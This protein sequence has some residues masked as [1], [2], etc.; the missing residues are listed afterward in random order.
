MQSIDQHVLISKPEKRSPPIRIDVCIIRAKYYYMLGFI[1][2]EEENLEKAFKYYKLASEVNP[3]NYAAHFGLGQINLANKNYTESI[4]HFEVIV[5]N[6]SEN[7][8]SDC[9]RVPFRYSRSWLTCTLSWGRRPWQ[10]NTT[11]CR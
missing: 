6:R 4:A 11:S 2:H 3:E 7:E 10:R 1:L 9:F 8:A 5:N